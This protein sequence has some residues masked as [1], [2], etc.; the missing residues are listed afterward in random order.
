MKGN[1]PPPGQHAVYI[2]EGITS[3]KYLRATCY[4]APQD[5]NMQTL[6]GLNL[7]VMIQPLASLSQ[8]EIDHG[9]Q[10]PPLVDNLPEGPF[11][12]ARCKAYVNPHFQWS[13]D[14]KKATCNLCLFE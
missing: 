6:S 5:N 1:V 3:P 14:G 8:I 9:A 10:E 7:G 13:Q 11:R 12:C 2:D 4:Q